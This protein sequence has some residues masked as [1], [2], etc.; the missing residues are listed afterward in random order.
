MAPAVKFVSFLL[1]FAL[2]PLSLFGCSGEKYDTKTIYAFNTM[3]ELKIPKTSSSAELLVECEKWIFTYESIFSAYDKDSELSNLNKN[4]GIPSTMSDHLENVIKS[5]LFLAS[6]TNGA[7]DPTVGE[8]VELWAISDPDAPIPSESSISSAL[9]LTGYERISLSDGVFVAESGVKL[10]LGGIA[11]GY[12]AEQISTF[13]IDSGVEFGVLSFGGNIAAFGEKPDASPFK[14]GIKN[15]AGGT[16]GSIKIN[17]DEDRSAS[18]VSVTGT[19]ERFKTVNGVKY[20]HIIDP[21][22]GYPVS[23]GLVSVA[24]LCENGA[25]ADALSTALFVMGYDEALK[26]YAESGIAFEAVFT[27]EDG[28]V[29]TTENC[30]FSPS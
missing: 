2:L 8:L 23:N 1:V 30:D 19:Y 5:A 22:N 27:F 11:K 17:S 29:L 16:F 13:L 6:K 25:Y 20:H 21:K 3:I 24:V 4:A 14:I 26:F 9:A 12:L 7:F 10:D 28:R 15:P 18:F